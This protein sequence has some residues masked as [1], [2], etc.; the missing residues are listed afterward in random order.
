MKI[1]IRITNDQD[2]EAEVR[3]IQ[4][5]ISVEEILSYKFIDLSINS[6]ADRLTYEMNISLKEM[7]NMY[8]EKQIEKESRL[9]L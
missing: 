8:V 1:A 5:M 4:Q 7:I 9:C 2:E 3:H 6:I